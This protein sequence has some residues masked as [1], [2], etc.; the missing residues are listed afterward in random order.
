MG[1]KA[2]TTGVARWGI[3][4]D[5][6]KCF[7][8][9][10]TKNNSDILEAL[11]A[12][13]GFVTATNSRDAPHRTVLKLGNIF[14]GKKVPAHLGPSSSESGKLQQAVGNPPIYQGFIAGCGGGKQVI[15]GERCFES[16]FEGA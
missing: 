10:L 11:G 4:W 2:K 3:L 12:D 5:K 14:E 13:H 6:A 8:R 9:F 1:E 15:G 16:Y 7:D